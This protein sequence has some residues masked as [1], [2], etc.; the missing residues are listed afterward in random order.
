MLFVCLC[1]DVWQWLESVCMLLV[2]EYNGYF[3]LVLLMMM[4][5]KQ[6]IN[7]VWVEVGVMFVGVL[8]Q[9]GLVDEFIVYI[10]FKLLGNVVCG[11]CVLLG[12]EELSQVFYFKFN[13]ICQVGLDVCLYLIIV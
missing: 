11:L 7:S 5:G 9:V 6:Q 3:D 13:E 8:L 10:V 12:F 2:L 4:F 1:V